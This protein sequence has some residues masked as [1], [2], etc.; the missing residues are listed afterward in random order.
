M[1]TKIELPVSVPGLKLKGV[2]PLATTVV[3]HK[4]TGVESV[5]NNDDVNLQ[6]HDVKRRR[7]AKSQG[8]A[9][10][11]DKA[12]DELTVPELKSLPEWS[13]VQNKKTITNKEGVLAAIKAVREGPQ[14]DPQT[15][16]EGE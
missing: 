16:N 1:A 9:A 14:D 6:T 11:V 10:S 15:S 3:V 12:L 13:D 8:N 4:E 7:L 5:V 2:K